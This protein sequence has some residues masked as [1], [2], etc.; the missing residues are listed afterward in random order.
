MNLFLEI[1][2]INVSKKY[3]IPRVITMGSKNVPKNL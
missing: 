1:K 3:V 2:Q